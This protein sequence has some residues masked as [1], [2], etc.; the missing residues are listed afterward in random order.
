MVNGTS[1]KAG[2]QRDRVLFLPNHAATGHGNLAARDGRD[3]FGIQLMFC[4]MDTL[5]Q[6][7]R[8]VIVQHWHSLLADDRSGIHAGIHKMH[9]ATRHANPMRERLFPCLQSGKRRQQRRMDIDDAI[10]ERAQK[11]ALKDTHESRKHDQVHLRLAQSIHKFSFRLF[12]ELGAERAWLDELR[13]DVPFTR[14][15]QDSRAFNIAQNDGDLRWDLAGGQGI[16]DGD[17]V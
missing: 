12:A 17:K 16:G 15:R 14:V 5:V 2:L 6:A 7:F 13:G 9:R 4:R 10:F 11:I 1:G 3:T 8:G